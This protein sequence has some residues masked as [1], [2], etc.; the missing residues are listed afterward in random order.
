MKQCFYVFLVTAVLFSTGCSTVSEAG[1]YWG[2]YPETLYAYQQDPSKESLAAHEQELQRLIEYANENDLSTP[3]GIL[4]ELGYIE[5][6]R[7]NPSEALRYYESEMTTYPESRPF[8]ERLLTDP[9]RQE[10]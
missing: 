5:Q 10:D 3:P 4:A 8:L 6:Q 9:Q 2:N 1:Y 7:G